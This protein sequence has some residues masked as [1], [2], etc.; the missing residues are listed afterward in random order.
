MRHKR[1]KQLLSIIL[2]FVMVFSIMPH[3]YAEGKTEHT[4][5]EACYARAG[6]L[7]CDMQ[8]SESHSHEEACYYPA[9]EYICDLVESEG[10]AHSENC[11]D[12]ENQSNFTAVYSVSTQTD[13]RAAIL[14]INAAVDGHYLISLESDICLSEDNGVTLTANST[15]I[16]GNNHTLYWDGGQE[17]NSMF[18]I[19][20][21]DTVL[22]LGHPEGEHTLTL[23][24]NNKNAKSPFIVLKQS[25]CMNI[26]P[27]VTI[28]NVFR[29][30]NG[31]AIYMKNATL[32]MYGGAIKYCSSS[33]DISTTTLICDGAALYAEDSIIKMHNGEISNN[34]T[35]A[36]GTLY[37]RN[38]TFDMYH[39]LISNNK[40]GYSG[41]GI[42][43]SACVLNLLG[44][45]IALNEC[46]MQG[47][48]IN[49]TSGSTVYLN[50]GSISKNKAE[51]EGGAFSIKNKSNFVIRVI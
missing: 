4:H 38:C 42:H 9:D 12:A 46:K 5:T 1:T 49:A 10:H 29:E 16:Y 30:V 15:T 32:N 3:A 34:I 13:F 8:E 17:K 41:G 18:I 37:M 2:I 31:A 33:Q 27:G 7:L 20:G 36:N 21:T 23:D 48:G 47:G 50:G 40:T 26:Y 19:Q 22:N 14:E 25:S 35:D 11:Y 51:F 24:G 6:D 43:S 28:Q 39:G 44:G 45:N